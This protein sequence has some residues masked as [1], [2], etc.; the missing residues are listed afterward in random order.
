MVYKEAD[1]QL[2]DPPLIDTSTAATTTRYCFSNSNPTLSI[3]PSPERPRL[4]FFMYEYKEGSRIMGSACLRSEMMIRELTEPGCYSKPLVAVNL[5]L[6]FL[7]VAIALL[8][9]YQVSSLFE[10]Q[11]ISTF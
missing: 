1:Y 2:A 9:F 11:S 10:F 5:A 6:A 7:D 8:A 3:N 4:Q